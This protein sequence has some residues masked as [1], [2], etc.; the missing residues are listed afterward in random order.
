MKIPSSFIVKS[1]IHIWS[2]FGHRT[3]RFRK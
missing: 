2:S 1:I 3:W